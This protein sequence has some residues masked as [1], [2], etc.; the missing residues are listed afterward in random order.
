M[1]PVVLDANVFIAATGAGDHFHEESRRLLLTLAT[2]RRTVFVPAFAIVEVACALS[3]RLRDAVAARKLTLQVM[4]AV[5]AKE[6]PVDA[7][8]LAQATLSGTRDFLRG[9]DALYAAAA[10]ME[11]ATLISW[12]DEH[13]TRAGAR[14][15]TEWL[16][17]Q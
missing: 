3:R 6:L 1:K 13:R 16:S 5:R 12:D 4:S 14:T 15:P 17:A 7:A 2:E 10:E 11:S 9:A 8:F